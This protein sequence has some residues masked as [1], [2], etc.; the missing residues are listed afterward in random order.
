MFRVF[1]YALDIARVVL[2]LSI[3]LLATYESFIVDRSAVHNPTNYDL[4]LILDRH[5][6]LVFGNI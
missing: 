4:I 2:S 1:V 5:F 6:T 3:A